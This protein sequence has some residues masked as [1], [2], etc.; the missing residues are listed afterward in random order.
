MEEVLGGEVIL[1]E[2]EIVDMFIM[3]YLHLAMILVICVIGK[4]VGSY[5]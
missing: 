1:E 4:F 2:E 3:A 5:V